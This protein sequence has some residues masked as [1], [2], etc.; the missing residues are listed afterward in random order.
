MNNM[1]VAPLPVGIVLYGYRIDRVLGQGGFGI[2]Y[3]CTKLDENK[4]YVIK[5][6]IPGIAG[7]RSSGELKFRWVDE[8]AHEDGTGSREWA[9][10]NFIREATNLSQLKHRGIVE[11]LEAFKCAETG[12]AYYTMSYI[13]PY[14]LSHCLRQNTSKTKEW[15]LYLLASLLDSLKYVHSKKVLHRDIK[16]ENILI[17]DNGEPVI[18]DF[19]SAR[20][21]EKS[22]KTRIVSVNYSPI[23]QMR[24]SGEGPWTDLY[25]LAA[26]IYQV[27]TNEY[28]PQLACRGGKKDEY[29]PLASRQE[30]VQQ[31]GFPLLSSLDKALAFEPEDRYQSAGEWMDALRAEPAFQFVTPIMLP[32]EAAPLSPA[33]TVLTGDH[34]ALPKKGQKQKSNGVLISLI[35]FLVLLLLGGVGGG[36]WFWIQPNITQD[37]I[38]DTGKWKRPSVAQVDSD[39]TPKKEKEQL[40]RVI[41]R[42]DICMYDVNTK[43][44]MKK[45]V[46]AFAVY[47][48]HGLKDGYHQ[49]SERPELNSEIVGLFKAED[50]NEWP[51][52]LVIDFTPQGGVMKRD[53]A[54]FFNTADKAK[55]FITDTTREQRRELV[56]KSEEAVE[57]GDQAGLESE[58]GIV[59]IEPT[60]WGSNYR[61]LPV[62]DYMKDE[63]SPQIGEY[64]Y[65]DVEGQVSSYVLKIAAMTEKRDKVNTPNTTPVR[66]IHPDVDM[67]FVVDTTKSM[68]PYI[69]DVRNF[70][71]QQASQL[72]SLS[73]GR[74]RFGLVAFRDWKRTNDGR[75]DMNYLDYT[76][77][78][79]NLERNA[80]MTIQEF[81]DSVLQLKDAQV[82]DAYDLRETTEDSID[83]REDV[84]YGIQEAIH[85]MPWRDKDKEADE[86]NLRFIV[87]IG[88]APG[89]LPEEQEDNSLRF[90]NPEWKNR[91]AGSY[92]MLDDKGIAS[93][94]QANHIFLQSYFILTPMPKGLQFKGSKSPSAMKRSRKVW[95]AYLKEG[96]RQ[97]SEMSYVDPNMKIGKCCTLVASEQFLEQGGDPAEYGPVT[98]GKFL[99]VFAKTMNEFGKLVGEGIDVSEEDDNASAA[100][101]LFAGAYV[102]WFSKQKPN[103]ENRVDMK[104]W[105]QSTNDSKSEMLQAKVV[106]NRKQVEQIAQKMQSVVDGVKEQGG[107][108][109]DE[110]LDGIVSQMYSMV[111]DPNINNDGQMNLLRK[112]IANLP[113]KSDLLR[114][115]E[116]D[117][118]NDEAS[119][120]E[121]F[122]TLTSR[123]RYMQEILKSND[124]CIP[125]PSGDKKQDLFMIPVNMLP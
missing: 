103:Q 106:L 79:Y 75:Y 71:S 121:L 72:D 74:I 33:P 23:E 32:R 19:G 77:K 54:L 34:V 27:I 115:V 28:V 110:A 25:A 20:D 119:K 53:R 107:T 104:G 4:V 48:S 13:S 3:L 112:A 38:K 92:C 63:R 116:N 9:E 8:S 26:S 52:N 68:G 84:F 70:I 78:N 47:Y 93:L 85:N 109:I 90:G 83:C 102:N 24:G 98:S 59:A 81:Q 35:V 6:N 125:D 2:T 45:T 16:P 44:P 37:E 123:I 41:A 7:R 97:Y 65:R 30:L 76:V 122:K 1:D 15:V 29:V 36:V 46:P 18:I 73:E 5:E 69:D 117:A 86:H 91:P 108:A 43:E 111:S 14:S 11:V 87:L 42:P 21:T 88:D 105:T 56:R 124:T 22:H 49:I 66:K 118:L 120:N 55:L 99:D 67:V 50:I 39:R 61:L 51:F 10:N 60:Q 89:R 80:M 82:S 100:K 114:A 57:G 17:A 96:V 101:S 12:T 95:D 64:D 94:L 40:L 113:Y 31:Y 62:L 58:H